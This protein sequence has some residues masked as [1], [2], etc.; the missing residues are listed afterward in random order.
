[1]PASLNELGREHSRYIEPQTLLLRNSGATL[2]VPKITLIGGCINDGVAAL[3]DVGYPLKFE[4]G[5]GVGS[6]GVRQPPARHPPSPV[7]PSKGIRQKTNQGVKVIH[8]G[9]E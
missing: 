6:D 1:V 8:S 3:L 9:L 2:G 5:G 7:H 4:C